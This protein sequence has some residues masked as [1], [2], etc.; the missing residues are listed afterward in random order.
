MPKR[1][2]TSAGKISMADMKNAINKRAGM[3]VAHDLNKANPTE[4]T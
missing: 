4:V 3:N 1:T 2:K